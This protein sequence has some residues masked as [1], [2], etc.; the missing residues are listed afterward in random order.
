MALFLAALALTASQASL[1]LSEAQRRSE[2]QR[3]FDLGQE[4]MHTEAFE[5]AV[6]EFGAAIELDPL[7]VLA[8]YNRGQAYMALKLYPEA[9]R[10]YLGCRDAVQR[11]NSLQQGQMLD[12]EREIED[13]INALKELMERLRHER[14]GDPGN[15]IM[16]VEARIR[17][18]EGLRGKGNDHQAR[19]P[20]ELFLAL[21]SAY[22]RQGAFED[23]EREYSAAVK[24]D[25]KLGAAYNNLAVIYMMGNRFKQAHEALRKAEKAGFDV[26]PNLK[27]D[28]AAREASGEAVTVTP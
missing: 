6:R 1:P 13:Q 15:R 20:A 9:V 23:A 14:R 26:N 16:M 24:A 5:Q 18:I 21:G 28:L 22:Y 7:L 11:L 2:A 3:H 17:V 27:R 25:G 19:V 8:H 4:S 10:S 12:R